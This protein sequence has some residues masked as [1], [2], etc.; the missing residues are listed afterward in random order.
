MEEINGL[1]I[2]N[3]T[4]HPITFWDEGWD[5]VVVVQSDATISAA[6]HESLVP[7]HIPGIEFVTTEFVGTDEGDGVVN[8]AQAAGADIIIG[9][10]IAAQAFPGQVVA[11]VPCKGFE[12]VPSAEKRMRW[13]KFTIFQKQESK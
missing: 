3:G 11:M 2:F 8:S 13:D 9:S 6:V 1:R 12:R 4:P 5:G 7:S 10:I